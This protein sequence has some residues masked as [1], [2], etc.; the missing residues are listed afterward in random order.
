[1]FLPTGFAL[2]KDFKSREGVVQLAEPQGSHH[3]APGELRIIKS[4][5][6]EDR[7]CPPAEAR[8]LGNL[9]QLHPNII[10]LFCCDFNI[11][12]NKGYAQMLFEFC[13]GGDLLQQTRY[14]RAT[15]LFA[16][17]LVI[18]IAEA[19]AFLHHGLIRDAQSPFYTKVMHGEA[20]VHQDIKADNVFL[21]SP[22][23]QGDLLP[24]LV[25]ANFAHANP[26]SQT[27][28]G[29]GCVAFTSHE[30]FYAARLSHKIDIY[31]FGVMCIGLFDQSTSDHWPLFKDPRHLRLSSMYEDLDMLVP[32]LK[33][34]VAINAADRG[35]FSDDPNLEMLSSIVGLKMQLNA[36][37][38]KGQVP[39]RSYWDAFN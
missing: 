24:D 1:M 33:S 28:P 27:N 29:P 17:H 21:R 32:L 23:S 39:D 8:I 38:S 6:H 30:R 37:A 31:S 18:S 26:A 10:R 22:G 16:L 12:G 14:R 9:A 2:I 36:L 4:V 19:L 35:E 3:H 15:P 5:R 13:P 7:S 11:I 34:C 20:I 25:L